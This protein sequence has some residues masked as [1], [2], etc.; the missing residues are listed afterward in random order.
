MMDTLTMRIGATLAFIV[1]AV[2][3]GLVMTDILGHVAAILIAGGVFMGSFFYR[4]EHCAKKGVVINPASQEVWEKGLGT[5]ALVIAIGML[6]F[7]HLIP[8]IFWL[9]VG[10]CVIV[11]ML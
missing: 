1:G 7:P 3:V 6:V 11:S 4:A 10:H 9:G 2:L 5:L 8:V